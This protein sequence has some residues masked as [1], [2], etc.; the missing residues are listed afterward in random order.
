MSKMDELIEIL[1]KPNPSEQ[2]WKRFYELRQ[3]LVD[4]SLIRQVDNLLEVRYME[5]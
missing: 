2:D 5:A 4:E 3:T 1:K